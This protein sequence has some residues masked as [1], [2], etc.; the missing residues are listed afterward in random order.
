MPNITVY[1]VSYNEEIMLP[2]MI[3]HY[4]ERF[5]KC[6]IVVYDNQSTDNT[7]EI[8]RSNNCEIR[9]Y[10]SGNKHDELLMWKTKNTCY[11][12]AKTDWVL[13]CDTDELLDISEDQLK[14][15]EENGVTKI[16]SI[17]YHMV[18]KYDNFDLESINYGFRDIKSY[19]GSVY[20]KDLLFNKKHVDINYNGAGCHDT[21]SSGN[22]VNSKP[23]NL[24]HYK[25]CNENY[26]V[27]KRAVT[28]LNR[29]NDRDRKYGYGVECLRGEQKLREEYHYVRDH[30]IRLFDHYKHFY[31]KIRGWFNCQDLFSDIINKLPNNSHMVEIGVWRGASTSY[32]AIE[33]IN[34]GKNIKLDVVDTWKGSD[35]PAYNPFKEEIAKNGGDIFSI[36]LK[37]IEPVKHIVNPIQ[38]PSLEAVKLY[39]DRSLDFVFIDADHSYEAV[40]ADIL[41]WL[42]K[43]KIGSWFGGHDYNHPSLPGVTK[44]V[45]EILGDKVI[46]VKGTFDPNNPKNQDIGFNNDSWLFYVEK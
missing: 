27:N 12:D 4:R 19:N 37:N 33:I 40:K 45:K 34:S 25:Y 22:V 30:S 23:Y 29:L 36:F 11:K 16:K 21:S 28:N 46:T 24:F 3:K 8:A 7:A 2:F 32:L 5:P 18:N 14:Q 26:F 31:H 43:M 13:I 42:P 39:D 20:D 35:D 6:H 38:K 41:A 10:N 44:A 17:C 9:Y 15:E 1:T